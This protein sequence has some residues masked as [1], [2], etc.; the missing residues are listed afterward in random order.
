MECFSKKIIIPFVLFCG[1]A[2]PLVQ[3]GARA[4]ERPV[5]VITT[6]F[7]VY[8]FV[9][10]V[11]GDTVSVTLLVPPGV[12]VHT[13]EPRPADIVEINNA[14]VFIFTGK[15]ME[16]WV[17]NM[18]KGMPRKHTAIVDISEGIELIDD[19][20]RDE[21]HGHGHFDGHSGKDPH[22]W[23]DLG[24]A[25][26]MVDGIADIL[27]QKD[28]AHRDVYSKNARMYKAKLAGLDERFKA[29]FSTCKY[30]TIIYGGHFA[31]GYFARRYGLQYVSP[32]EGFSPN[33][34]PG[35]RAIAE[36]IN[37]LKQ[38][39]QKY[40]YYEELLDPK[41]ARIVAGETGAR[42][43]LLHAAH[44]ISKSELRRGLSFFEIMEENLRKL[45]IGLV[46]Q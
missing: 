21:L 39:G 22:I 10:Q 11:G 15:Y 18:F 14:D 33:A 8:D 20:G 42:L 34:E 26:R 6:I 17:E 28:P 32:Y 9:K 25:Q 1:L 7:P 37:R 29:M 46:C 4:V 45:K 13:F 23:L 2:C 12:E 27:I 16:P 44:N 24:N 40:I 43:M 5:T 36:I 31:F 38:S 19:K 41:V 3:S 35:P 30:K